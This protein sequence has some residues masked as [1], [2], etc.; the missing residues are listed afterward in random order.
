MTIDELRARLRTEIGDETPGSYTWPD[1]LLNALLGD[2]VEQLGMDIPMR[3]TA[4]LA[5]AADGSYTLPLGLVRLLRVE[6]SGE[7]LLRREYTL[8]GRTLTAS[9]YTGPLS[10]LYDGMR[11]RPGVGQ[12][13]EITD[14]E[15]M[16]V[17]WLAASYAMRWLAVQ[18]ERLGM[19]RARGAHAAAQEYAQR[20]AEWLAAGRR[21][22]Q[23][24]A[25]SA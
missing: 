25:L 24:Y 11:F 10:I 23:R 22:L 9:G 13:P 1:P 15:A 16:P 2:G 12:D 4:E 3:R 5:P 21:P 19:E 7:L 18:R 17:V 14:G 6:S 20:Y 8:R